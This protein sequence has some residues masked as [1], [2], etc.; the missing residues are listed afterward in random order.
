MK[1]A[2]H[3]ARGA[4][5]VNSAVTARVREMR[6]A[7]TAAV[8]YANTPM[9]LVPE[10]A[11]AMNASVPRTRRAIRQAAR[12]QAHKKQF[13]TASAFALLA[14]TAGSLTYASTA[15]S[16][17]LPTADKGGTTL[18]AD[19]MA[20]A[21]AAE[22]ATTQV[23]RSEERS[24]TT[25]AAASDSAQWSLSS[26]TDSLDASQMSKS[27]ANN[28]KVA[29]FMDRDGDAVPAGFNPNHDTGDTGNAYAFSQC[30]WWA[31]T[32]RHQLNLPVGSYFGDGAMWADSARAHGYWVDNTPRVGDVMVFQRGQ[33]GA[34]AQYGHVAIV[35][36]VNADGSVTTSE[37]G[38]TYNGKPFSRTF[39]NVHDFQYI[40]Y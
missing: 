36:K 37:C 22:S 3:K 21:D 24:A 38:A 16:A 32:R 6:A 11:K 30:T 26:A 33:E 17:N 9:A 15:N 28:A 4:Q 8:V 39:K 1:H 5:R 10:V 18:V 31:Y 12:Q 7:H 40:H 25:Q 23:S 2:A 29:A 34:S 20:S 14:A 27:K 35:E 13:I 19:S